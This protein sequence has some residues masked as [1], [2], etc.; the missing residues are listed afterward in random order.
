VRNRACCAV[1][2]LVLTLVAL[3]LSTFFSHPRPSC[4]TTTQ[5]PWMATMPHPPS[6]IVSIHLA[7][8]PPCPSTCNGDGDGDGSLPPPC[9]PLSSRPHPPRP[10][11]NMTT[12]I[13]MHTALPHPQAPDVH[14]PHTPCHT[15]FMCTLPL[16]LPALPHT[17]LMLAAATQ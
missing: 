14:G 9:P 12:M 16:P 6:C 13:P 3:A 10:S 2:P 5:P 11:L 7:P 1:A 4:S 8:H 17:P 15:H